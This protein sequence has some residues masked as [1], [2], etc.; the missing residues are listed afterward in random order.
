M[1][2]ADRNRLRPGRA[3]PIREPGD[4]RHLDGGD[5]LALRGHPLVQAERQPGVDDGPARAHE[6][7]VELWPGLSS[8]REDVLE[9]VRGDERDPCAATLQHGVGRHR[10]AMDDV[11]GACPVGQICNPGEDGPGR[12]VRGRFQFMY[13]EPRSRQPH[14]VG[15]GPAGVDAEP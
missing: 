1:Q 4:V 12:I 8:D 15:E 14:E 10:G 5:R 6:D 13:G 9:A 2:Q 11:Q 3:S 7:V